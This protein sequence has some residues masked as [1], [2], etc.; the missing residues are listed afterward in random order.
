MY[1]YATFLYFCVMDP[2]FPRILVLVDT[3][4]GWGR[5]LIRGIANYGLTHGPWQLLVEEKAALA[6]LDI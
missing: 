6:P 5:R 3:S 1:I 2:P 4:S